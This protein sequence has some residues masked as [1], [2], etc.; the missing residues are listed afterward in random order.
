MS[1]V[2]ASEHPEPPP[3]IRLDGVSKHFS[4]REGRFD[5]VRDVS[6]SV[7][8]GDT[9]GLIGKSGAGKSTLLRLINLLERPDA[10]AVHVAGMEL[11]ALGKRALREA[12]QSI[13]MI[14][15]QFNL[16]QNETVFENV[17]FPLRVH[18]GRNQA[19]L[20]ARVDECLDIVDLADKRGSHP[21]QLSGGQKQRVAI[22]RA[23]ASE[24]AVLL[25]DEPTSALDPE[26]TRSV[27]GVLRDINRRLG[28]TIVIV[29]H[30]LAVVRAL[31]R[32]VAVMEGGRIVEQAEISRDGVNLATPLGRELIREASHPYEEVA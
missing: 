26:T 13:G 5:A 25:C 30:E 22:A 18:G 8:Q 23:L 29:T 21:A 31:C 4:T 9:F 10:G 20:T 1:V 17:A 14:F 15:Q 2:S 3:V 12:R 11:T 7:R 16:L 6:L 24:P 19:Q 28:V 27:L 32:H